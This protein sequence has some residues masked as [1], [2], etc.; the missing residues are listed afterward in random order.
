MLPMENLPAQVT[1]SN[2]GSRPSR[3]DPSESETQSGLGPR[4]NP[5]PMGMHDIPH[6]P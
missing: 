3:A 1:P 5:E 4:G 2:E 6:R